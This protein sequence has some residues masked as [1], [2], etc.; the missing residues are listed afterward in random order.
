M[1][2]TLIL[3]LLSA[4]A[5]MKELTTSSPLD[6]DKETSFDKNNCVLT[7]NNED[8]AKNFY[9]VKITTSTKTLSCKCE[10]TGAAKIEPLVNK[11]FILKSEKGQCDITITS[12]SEDIFPIQGTI[13]VHPIKNTIQADIAK[14]K[15]EIGNLLES[16][17]STPPIV[18][19][20]SNLENDTEIN[21]A[22]SKGNVTINDKKFYLS[23]PFEVCLGND[24]KKNIKSYK[25][26]KGNNYEIRTKFEE[27]DSDNKKYYYMA[28]F[29]F[30]QDVQ[31][32]PDPDPAPEPETDKETDTTG[33]ACHLTMTMR[34]I[35]LLLYIGCL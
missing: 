33:N 11:Y 14:N 34:L 1:Y 20:V 7:F 19:S 16:D 31:P 15:Y 10:C 5:S 13:W 32:G 30:G 35:F 8:E 27:F 17:E 18:Y 4:Y 9:L 29:S 23:N 12:P 22:Y 21:F 24:C 28:S 6:F 2:K 25:F 3:F 26:L